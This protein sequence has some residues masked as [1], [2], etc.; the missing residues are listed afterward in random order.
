MRGGGAFLEAIADL[1]ATMGITLPPWGMP[2]LALAVFILLLPAIWRNL[3]TGQSRT[4]LKRA[5]VLEGAERKALEDKAFK[6]VWDNPP[7]LVALVKEAHDRGR[8]QVRDAALARLF[9]LDPSSKEGRRL[10]KEFEPK[11]PTSSVEMEIIIE[12]LVDTGMV[13]NAQARLVQARRK[14]PA[15]A[16]AWDALEARLSQGPSEQGVLLPGPGAHD[17]GEDEADEPRLAER[18]GA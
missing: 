4:L 13:E 7:G 1:L 8:N 18:G 17:G 14:W 11:L 5:S 12:R 9:E 16:A 10:R 2:A 3:N 15:E 6:V